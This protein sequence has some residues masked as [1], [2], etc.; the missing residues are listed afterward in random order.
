[1]PIGPTKNF[2]H[3]QLKQVHDD[4]ANIANGC[5]VDNKF[6]LTNLEKHVL[7]MANEI[8]FGIYMRER[9]DS[10]PSA[11]SINPRALA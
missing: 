10:E 4:V 8:L 3:D 2:T 5:R 11:N 7:D 9:Y 1:M 6:K